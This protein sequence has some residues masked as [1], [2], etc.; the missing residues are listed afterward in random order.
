MI[1]VD[2]SL[3]RNRHLSL[4]YRVCLAEI[5]VCRPIFTALDGLNVSIQAQV[6]SLVV[7]HNVQSWVWIRKIGSHAWPVV[8][9]DH[10]C[11]P[12]NGLGSI[13]GCHIE[14]N[15]VGCIE[16]AFAAILGEGTRNVV[17]CL[18]GL[19]ESEVEEIRFCERAI[20]GI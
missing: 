18:S 13:A 20:V 4:D 17:G 14:H 6:G 8:V 11:R 10:V 19:G 15:R 3:E 2:R 5:L 1:R 12:I 16:C 7:K 9:G